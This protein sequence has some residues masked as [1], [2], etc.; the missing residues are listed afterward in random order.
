VKKGK[1]SSGCE[2][3]D[4]TWGGEMMEMP[5]ARSPTHNQKLL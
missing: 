4:W 3:Q 2:E 5:E 1:I